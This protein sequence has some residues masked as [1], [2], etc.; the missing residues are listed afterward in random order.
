MKLIYAERKLADGTLEKGVFISLMEFA[1]ARQVSGWSSTRELDLM[2]DDAVRE[3]QQL[4]EL[5]E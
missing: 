5:A 4:Q 3:A 1:N 2:A